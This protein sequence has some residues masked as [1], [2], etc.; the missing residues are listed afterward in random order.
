MEARGF[1]HGD[2]RNLATQASWSR[3]WVPRAQIAPRFIPLRIGMAAERAGPAKPQARPGWDN[4]PMATR[5]RPGDRG[6]RQLTRD[7]GEVLRDLR[8]RRLTL[9]LSQASVAAA[10]GVSRSLIGRIERDELGAPDLGDIGAIAGA[11]GLRLRIGIYPDGQPIAD[12]VQLRLLAH[13]GQQLHPGLRWRMEVP[14]PISGDLRAWDAVVS[15]DDDR[16]GIEGI[17][18]LGAVDATVRRAL[19][20]QRDD[21][22]IRSV[23]LVVADTVRNRDAI[24][25]AGNLLRDS[26]PLDSAAV[27]RDLRRGRVPR[28]NGTV[29]LRVPRAG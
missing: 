29:L 20:K 21:A 24:A 25:A 18:R 10:T 8:Q 14:L 6:R 2:A 15:S 26:F 27:M 11:L 1:C 12:G 3:I 23:V 7:R 17:S 19:H 28:L 4:P 13:L 22:R 9:G 5:E 16:A